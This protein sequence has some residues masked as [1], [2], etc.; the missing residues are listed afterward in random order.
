MIS[1]Y[2]K[3][4]VYVF[5]DAANI[6]H[7][8][9]TLGWRVD[10]IRLKSFFEKNTDLG[11]IYYYTA[12]DPE[13]PQQLNF[14]DFLEIN[15]YIIRKKKIKFI[16]DSRQKE[17]GFHKGNLDV[18]LAIDAVD[19]K[20]KFQ[21]FILISGDSD[22]EALLKYMRAYRKNCLVLSTQDHV[23]LELLQ[24]AKF[25]DLKKLRGELKLERP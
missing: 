21:S 9:K 16:K 12:Y 25:I 2:V 5:I 10:F 15:G 17:G 13:Y 4:K 23:S 22:F 20:N 1:Q 19:T 8:Q 14:L 11:Q 3:G 7:S 24:Q 18:E 6:Y